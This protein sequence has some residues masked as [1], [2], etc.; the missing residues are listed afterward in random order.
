[1]SDVGARYRGIIMLVIELR[2]IAK[3]KQPVIV[4]DST[5][6]I[7]NRHERTAWLIDSN[8]RTE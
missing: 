8:A 1:M 2:G 4:A 6:S 5:S 7:S 3:T